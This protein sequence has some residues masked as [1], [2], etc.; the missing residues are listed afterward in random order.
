M[1]IQLEFGVNTYIL[2]YT[3]ITNNDLQYSTGNYPCGSAGRVCLQCGRPGFDP[4]VGKIP[5][6]RERL[7]T[8]VFW[9][10]E[11]HGL[12]SPRGR[13]DMTEQLSLSQG[14][15]SKNIYVCITESLCYT[16]E[17]IQHCKSVTLQENIHTHKAQ[18]FIQQFVY[19]PNEL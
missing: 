7:P 1:G 14:K 16:S 13:E 4:W 10:G 19:L 2:L 12:Y 15:E 6:K 11:F 18:L 9:P 5:W 17:T 8:P 3:Q